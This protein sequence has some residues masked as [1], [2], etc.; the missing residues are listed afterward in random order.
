[1]L[2]SSSEAPPHWLPEAKHAPTLSR[3]RPRIHVR[4][5][6]GRS[7][8]TGSPKGRIVLEKSSQWLIFTPGVSVT[9]R[10]SRPIDAIRYRDLRTALARH[11]D[12]PSFAVSSDGLSI[13]EEWVEGSML[14]ASEPDEAV[15]RIGGLVGGYRHLVVESGS[16]ST[17]GEVQGYV[18]T[19]IEA[20]ARSPLDA[21]LQAILQSSRFRR[22]ASVG[23]AIASHG[24]AGAHNV[25]AAGPRTVLIDWE[26]K[27]LGLRPFWCDVVMLVTA[28]RRRTGSVR[29]LD[30]EVHLLLSAA[31][32]TDDGLF[33]DPEMTAAAGAFA[34]LCR[35]TTMVRS[36]TGGSA[37]VA[38]GPFGPVGPH[39]DGGSLGLPRS[40]VRLANSAWHRRAPRGT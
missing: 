2:V 36:G 35:R 32:V 10:L 38:L 18:A 24:E 5:P 13:M 15:E 3:L 7:Q 39:R 20:A 14:R 30:E 16:G 22:A 9:R 31:E 19:M 17:E 27:H 28:V 8:S 21:G 40:A 4:P 29:G 25:L 23:P 26:P 11:V 6:T 33:S 12:S 34:H 37:T 1:V